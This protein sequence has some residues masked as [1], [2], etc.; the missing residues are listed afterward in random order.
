MSGHLVQRSCQVIK[1][2]GVHVVHGGLD[3]G[4][5]QDPHQNKRAYPTP[6][7]LGGEGMAQNP[8]R[9]GEQP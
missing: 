7:R 1:A 4:M 9:S 8:H 3:V 5:A 6:D 2:A